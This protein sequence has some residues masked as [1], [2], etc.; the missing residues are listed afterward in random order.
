VL[1]IWSTFSSSVRRETKSAAR[2]CGDRSGSRKG[3]APGGRALALALVK[4]SVTLSHERILMRLSPV[5][6]KATENPEMLPRS[7]CERRAEGDPFQYFERRISAC[8][9]AAR[10][11]E[12][13]ASVELE[14]P[15]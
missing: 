10:C 13:L 3:T 6:A 11:V 1:C 14:T 7:R 5:L 8:G 9:E 2:R 12:L 4:Q 15:A